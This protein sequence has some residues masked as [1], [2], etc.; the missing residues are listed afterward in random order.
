MKQ[1]SAFVV[2]AFVTG[3]LLLVP[4]YLAVL[5]LLKAMQSAVTTVFVPRCPRLSPASSLSSVGNACILWRFPS[6]RRSGLSPG[7]EQGQKTL[8]QP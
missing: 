5:L 6:H 7:G 2:S 8:S 1:I 3:L 4:I